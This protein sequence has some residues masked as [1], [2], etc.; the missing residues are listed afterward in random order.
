MAP[1]PPP[2][3][4]AATP[5]VGPSVVTPAGRSPTPAPTPSAADWAEV[6]E[7]LDTALEL[8]T[9]A[10][11]AWLAALPPAQVRLE[12]LLRELLRTHGDAASAGFLRLPVS[13]SLGS[14][15][16]PETAGATSAVPAQVGPY[17][18][19]REIGQGGM[20]TVWLAERA[21]GLLDRHVA[22]KLP[23]ASWGTT[24]FADR[25]ARERNI[26]AAL[27]HPH[28]ARLY[29]AGLAADGRPYLALEY[30]D[31]QP[32]H[33]HANERSLGLRARVELL[34]QVA[35]AVAHAHARRVVHRDLKPSNILVD[36][37][38]QAHLLDFGIARLLAPVAE[39]A[40]T[41]SPL[42]QATSRALTPDYASPEQIRGD[43]VGTAS[44][45]YSLGVVA[46]EL[47]AGVRPYRLPGGAGPVALAAAVAAASVPRASDAAGAGLGASAAASAKAGLAG[48]L[49]AILA[50]AL[51]KDVAER[52][53]SVDAF[54]QDLQRHL[55][56][57]PVLARR[58][59]LAYRGERWL[60]RH[61]VEAVIA[62]ALL[63]ALLLALVG[64]AYAQLLVFLALGGGTAV[65]LWQRRQA[66]T[67]TERAR[68]ALAR[69]EQVK[70]F[71]A[72]IFTQA[73]PR[74][75]AGGAVTAADLLRA[76]SQ[77]IDTDLQAQ[78]EVA[79]E[80]SLLIGAGFNQLGELGAGLAW[81][82]HAVQRCTDS[83]GPLHPQTL[84]ARWRLVEAANSMGELAVAEPLLAPLVADLRRVTTDHAD[85][86]GA[87]SR[88]PTLLPD[89]LAEAL[90]SQAFALSKRGHA[91]EAL[92][93][94]HEALA[95]AQR[96][97]DPASDAVLSARDS[98]SN[99]LL[100][101]DRGEEAL[102]AIEPALA[103]ARAAYG[104]LRPHPL[105]LMVERAQ[106]S[107]LG[108][109]NRPRDAATGL[110]QV[111]ADQRA[112][113]VEET[114][115]VRVA[116]TM[117]VNALVNGGQVAQAQAL[118]EQVAAL[119]ERL[120]GGANH[121]GLSL[122][123][124]RGH[125]CAL[126][127]DADGALAHL[128]AAQVLA[129]RIGD[130]PAFIAQRLSLRVLALATAG[131]T[132]E[133]LAAAE[134]LL[135]ERATLRPAT[136]VRLLRARAMALRHSGALADAQQAVADALRE[137]V[138]SGADGATTADPAAP[139][140]HTRCGGLEHGLALVEAAHCS[141]AAGDTAQAALHLQAALAVW[142]RTQVDGPE[143][144][145]PVRAEWAALIA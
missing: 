56:G 9:A 52:Y 75:G 72:S 95:V 87:A 36:A 98:L 126:Q 131:R 23:H 97:H 7:L 43:A 120:T 63:L 3:V 12:P 44:D 1:L 109:S 58:Q 123:N 91:D 25:M 119:H 6:F 117:L 93:A 35:R 10:H 34:L 121:E 106:A 16:A 33:T 100:H 115:R 112:L 32:I 89:L 79:A 90:R 4:G 53:A 57:Q 38:G 30:I 69:A 141:R 73:T 8:D 133:A 77:R 83:F 144:V 17:R 13:P 94:L 22:L 78:P 39:K 20:A 137:A 99:T 68:A 103:P 55:N 110:R 70:D 116:M 84:Q 122:S 81:L 101:F 47:L 54:A 67:Q 88:D 27:V 136:L 2:T 92:A 140:T 66:V 145:D 21:D 65:A 28:I 114:T 15:A 18:L 143:L 62:A 60:R 138:Q 31:G 134:P 118:A 71:I 64:G 49:D 5:P 142:E 61:R 132:A 111:L 104:A 85:A 102:R 48:D 59:S 51:A 26:L 86:S 50:C 82:P 24:H 76:A 41:E 128:D 113:D 130:G 19:L 135:A 139:A 46:Y 107:A 11:P 124:T 80:L 105:L 125:L 37:Q 14:P 42:T 129:A 108:R 96:H 45:I 29:D 127:G 74:A 40:N